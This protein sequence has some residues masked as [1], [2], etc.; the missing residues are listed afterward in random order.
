MQFDKFV[1]LP[2]LE[3]TYPLYVRNIVNEMSNTVKFPSFDGS[4]GLWIMSDYGGEHK[5]A[6]FNTYSF[7]ICCHDKTPVYRDEC[8]KI[9]EKHSLNTPFKEFNYKDLDSQRVKASLDDFLKIADSYLHG[10]LVT[11]SVDKNIPSLF[12]NTKREGQR[13]IQKQLKD[14]GLG[15]W[16]G[17]IAEKLMRICHPIALYLSLLRSKT[18]KFMWLSDNDAINADGKKRSFEDTRNIFTR[19]LAMYTKD[20]FEI[21][22]FAK[23]FKDDPYTNDILSLTDFAAGAI[24]DILSSKVKNIDKSISKEQE[25]IFS[26]LGNDSNFLMK[27][28]FIFTKSK[29]DLWDV[30][31]VN[32]TN[33]SSSFRG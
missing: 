33:A 23:S 18:E 24:Q 2:K 17:E 20:P 22:G 12:G 6:G 4:K 3:D 14:S 30:G 15:E 8:K 29:T 1:F 27:H 5:G 7:L 9:R 31:K 19:V 10:V 13:F 16:K 21:Y 28:H 26:W 32:I 25:K 11:V